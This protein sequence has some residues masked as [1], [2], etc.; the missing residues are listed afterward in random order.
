MGPR[1]YGGGTGRIA[2]CLEPD[3]LGQANGLD[4]SPAV[5]FLSAARTLF[6]PGP[7]SAIIFGKMIYALGDWSAVTPEAMKEYPDDKLYFIM[8]E[9]RG[10]VYDAWARAEIQR[11]QNCALTE[12]VHSLHEA[13]RQVHQEVAI[14]NSSSNRMEH[15][16]ITLK[17]FTVALI[18]F[19]V[20]QIV[21]AGRS[22]VEDVPARATK[23]AASNATAS[24]DHSLL[25]RH[26]SRSPAKSGRH[27]RPGSSTGLAR[28]YS[29]ANRA[30]PGVFATTNL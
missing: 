19:A 12:V 7:W 21:I 2:D 30:A 25:R 8:Q 10:D 13:T 24:I 6:T 26:A 9:N 15:H 22:D 1:A 28:R 27:G 4:G 20:I 18:V 29:I 5:N 16:T 11:R 17:R 23:R 3:T 14:L